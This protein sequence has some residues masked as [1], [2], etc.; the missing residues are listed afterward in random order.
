MVQ[1][2]SADEV[3]KAMFSIGGDKAPGPD[4]F[5]ACFYHKNWAIVGHDVVAAVQYF[6]SHRCLPRGVECYSFHSC[7]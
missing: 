5:R 7:S 2:V 1:V 6:F 3:R 4:G